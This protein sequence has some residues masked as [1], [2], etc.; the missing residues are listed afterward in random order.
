MRPLVR[1]PDREKSVTSRP[2]TIFLALAVAI[3]SSLGGT[4]AALAEFPDR[5]IT[6]LAYTT[7][8][9]AADADSRKLAEIATR[10]T[11]AQFVVENM[12]GAGG[13]VAM[14]HVLEQPAD[15]YLLMATTKSQVCKIASARSD[16][17]VEDFLWLSLNQTDPEAI[18]VAADGETA[19]WAKILADAAAKGAAGAQQIWVGPAAGGL[20]HIMAMKTWQAAGI[21][22][23]S[24]RYMP[25]AGGQE[26]MAEVLAGRGAVYV[27][28]PQDIADRPGLAIA[29]LS[30]PSRL[31]AFP[32]AP[33][34]GELGLAGLDNEVMWRGFAIRA[35]IPEAAQAFWTDLLARVAA[36]PEWQAHVAG[37]FTDPV[38]ITGEAFLA[39]VR[40]D[41]AE[42]EAWYRATGILE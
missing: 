12:E 34:F 21:A 10:L 8:G 18:I 11:G 1:G 7:P 38:S 14:N 25:F 13:L 40:Q 6:I 2:R 27:G 24:V 3:A 5:P 17:D 28:N 20:D 31:A 26:A 23:D 16:I 22:P 9:G 4:Q 41:I 35:G 37:A 29:A 39:I 19:S 32:D 36:D 42:V 30:R 15:G 33:T